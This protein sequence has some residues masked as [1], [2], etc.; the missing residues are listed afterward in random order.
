MHENFSPRTPARRTVRTRRTASAATGALVV[1]L[2]LLSPAPALA[3]GSTTTTLYVD[4]GSSCSDT[5]PGTT[6]S[7]FCS[8]GAAVTAAATGD[9]ISVAAGTYAERVD[10]GKGVNLVGQGRT[11]RGR[12]GPAVRLQA[13][14]CRPAQRVHCAERQRPRV[15]SCPRPRTPPSRN[16]ST[17]GGTVTASS[18]M[19]APGNTLRRVSVTGAG[20]VGILLRNTDGNTVVDSTTQDNH[21]HGLSIQGGDGNVVSGVTASGNFKSDRSAAGID[22]RG[23]TPPSTSVLVKA[24]NTVVEGSTSLRQ[25]GLRHRD[26]SGLGR[27]RRCAATSPTT[28]ATT[29]STLPARPTPPS[30]PTRSWATP[31]WASTWRPAEPNGASAPPGRPCVTTS[32][33]RTGST[34][35]RLATGG[36]PGRRLPPRT[37]T[38]WTA[39]S[40]GVRIRASC[41]QFGDH[42]LLRSKGIAGR[43]R[44]Q[45]QNGSGR[46]PEVRSA[47]NLH[48]VRRLTRRRRRLRGRGGLARRRPGRQQARRQRVRGQHRRGHSELRG[49]RR[50]RADRWPAGE[51]ADGEADGHPGPASPAA[52][53]PPWTPP[54]PRR[55]RTGATTHRLHV[56]L[57]RQQPGLVDREHRPLPAPTRTAGSFPA[58]VTVTD[59]NNKT[60]SATTTITVTDPGA[61][62]DGEAG[63]HARQRDDRR[64]QHAGR[65]GFD[66][67][68]HS[69]MPSSVATGQPRWPARPSA[70][71][72]ARTPRPAPTP[73]RSPSPTATSSRRARLRPSRSRLRLRLRLRRRP[74]RRVRVPARRRRRRHGRH[75]RPS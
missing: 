3:A 9:T 12:L 46:R 58:K 5:G 75:L 4:G 18:W 30:S 17:T 40:C 35:R 11:D 26:L 65:H 67:H 73:P 32:P 22:V 53:P 6:A 37:G 55:P 8:I 71:L 43:P 27:T 2:G 15:S 20:T 61:G 31:T 23:Y 56:R 16:V 1:G 34:Q 69:P 68:R 62:T 49:H 63:R 50:L 19:G 45:E 42:V 66:R 54:A 7:P 29:A 64:F 72:S 52:A 44:G 51:R 57:R 24:T 48:L 10:V 14:R 70:R 60:A 41:F 28:T 21:N 36:D 33:R 39:T 74:R 13:L 47:S 38:R 25:R 59:S